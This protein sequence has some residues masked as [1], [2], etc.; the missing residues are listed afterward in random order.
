MNTAAMLN[1]IVYTQTLQGLFMLKDWPSQE[2]PREKLMRFGAQS[3]SDAELLAIFLRTGVQGCNVVDL[4]RQLLS[5]FGSLAALFSAEHDDFCQHR[6]LGSAKFVQLKACLEMSKRYLTEQLQ[7]GDALLSSEHTKAFLISEL[8][9]ETREI[10]CVLWLNNQHQVINFERL[11]YGTIDAATVHPRIVVEQ[12]LTHHAAAVIIAHNH[13]SG[14]AE[15]SIADQQITQRLKQA[16]Q[17]V[18][19]RLLDH[20]IVAGHQCYSL[21]EH[22]VL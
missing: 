9:H 20:L 7:Q 4:S 1:S 2:R 17:L 18:D 3:L 22:G 10:F 13:P 14:V 11:F 12:A 15:A 5:N 16:L 8:R 6:G 19:I 21:A